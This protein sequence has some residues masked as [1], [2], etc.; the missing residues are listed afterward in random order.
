LISL[1]QL[2][3]LGHRRA[4]LADGSIVRLDVFLAT[5]FWH[6]KLQTIAVTQAEGTPLVG[7]ALLQGSRLT[8]D[9]IDGGDVMADELS[10]TP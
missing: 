5:V 4:A 8:I 9:V 1:L 7:M 6:G 3:F 2:P 10:Q